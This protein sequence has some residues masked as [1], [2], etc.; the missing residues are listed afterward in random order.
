MFRRSFI[1]LVLISVG[2]AGALGAVGYWPSLYFGGQ[3][4]VV[5]MG[6]GIAVS[7]LASVIGT[8]P[9]CYMIASDAQK[10]PVAALLGN[11]IRMLL[12][13]LIVAPIAL[14]RKLD[15]TAFVFWVAIS[16]IVL[17][18]VDTMAP[19]SMLKSIRSVET[20]A[21]ATQD[22]KSSDTT[23]GKLDSRSA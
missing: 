16:Y 21:Q 6:F 23:T 7:L 13:M 4:W 3:T 18:V 17:L 20:D 10:A 14:S 1:K 8:I 9:V 19:V 15:N 5:G 22:M 12:V 2:C 11:C